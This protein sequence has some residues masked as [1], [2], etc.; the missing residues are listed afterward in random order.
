MGMDSVEL[1][2][3]FEE[4]FGIQITDEEATNCLTPRI[5]VDMIFSKL[6]TADEH[7]CRSQRAFYL[8]RRVLVQTFG[9]ERKSITPD[10]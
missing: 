4:A 9:L 1:V 3:S 10:M 5:V 8:I 7:V 2:I 6:K